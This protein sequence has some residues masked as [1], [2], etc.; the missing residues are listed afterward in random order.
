[1][2]DTFIPPFYIRG[3]F[4]QTLL[5]S[6]KIGT[7]RNNPV[8]EHAR[9]VILNPIDDVRLQGFYSPHADGQARGVVMLL[10]GWEGSVNS[11]YILR[12]GRFLHQNGF[13][14]FR[15]NYRDHGDTHHLNPGLFYAILLDEVFGVVQQ[16]AAYERELPFYVI[17]FSMGGNFALRIARRCI[18]HPIPNLKHVFSVSPVLDPEK[19]TYAIDKYPLLRKYFRKRWSQS[20]QKKQDLFPD[21]YNFNDVFQLETIGEMTEVMLQRYSEFKNP[22]DYFRQYAVTGDAL[23]ALTV[24]TTVLTAQDDPIIPSADFYDLKLPPSAELIV[25]RYGGHNGFLETLSGRVW[26]QKKIM[27]KLMMFVS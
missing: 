22:S 12:T 5:A 10:H 6:S 7:R 25:Q 21:L 15:L 27:E 11:A 20:L 3:T 13:S 23:A 18:E 26:Y 1:M 9:K 8:L 14:V 17:G 2:T 19:S 24:P 4:A 16:V